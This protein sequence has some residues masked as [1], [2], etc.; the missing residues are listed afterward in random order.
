MTRYELRILGAP[1][2]RAPDGGRVSSVLSQPSRLALLAYLTLAPGPVTRAVLVAAFWPESDEGRARNSL[3]QAVFYLRRSLGKHS[4][5]GVEG[6]RLWVP[7]EQVWCDAR[8]L[9]TD[10]KP[11]PDVLAAAAHDL[12]AGWNADGSQPLQE[13]LDAQRRSV[14][15]RRAE[16]D[17][18]LVPPKRAQVE[19][20][21]SSP[22]TQ[23]R[24]R[25][26]SAVGA[27]GLAA[28][29]LIALL[30]AVRPTQGT[31]T[32]YG[33]AAPATPSRLAVLMPRVTRSLGAPDLAALTLNAELIAQL[34]EM[35]DIEVVSASYA[36][37]L[38]DFMRQLAT[39]SEPG[40]DVPE[41]ILDVNVIV[42]GNAVRVVG[43]LYRGAGFGVPGRVSFD[44]EFGSP[45]ETVIEVP[46]AIA[47]RIAAM[48]DQVI[49]R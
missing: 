35:A 12:L 22:S 6:D 48:V 45:A 43:L 17:S 11:P 10:D 26:L 29:L 9:L 5:Q 46:R 41:W 44:Q 13:W 49:Q 32:R 8:V 30:P 18:D 38:Q 19:A 21:A 28:L 33:A 7:P 31:A 3:S 24:S 37:S 25:W 27:A 15:D 16:L 47:D 39:I 36:T 1:D 42:G 4:V 14:R 20:G 34:P 2:L 23:V 40:A